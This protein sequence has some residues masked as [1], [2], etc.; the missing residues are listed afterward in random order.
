[1]ARPVAPIPDHGV[2]CHCGFDTFVARVD[3]RAKHSSGLAIHE[4]AQQ[5][6]LARPRPQRPI[7]KSENYRRVEEAFKNR[8]KPDPDVL[9]R[10]RARKEVGNELERRLKAAQKKQRHKNLD[11][12]FDTEVVDVPPDPARL[13]QFAYRALVRF[14]P[15]ELFGPD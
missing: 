11:F 3:Q 13:A 8:N 1:M 14:T 6:A 12:T 9:R 5:N 2:K 15:D 4:S 7:P 10:V